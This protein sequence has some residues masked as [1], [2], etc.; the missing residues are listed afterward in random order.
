MKTKP[1]KE[2]KKELKLD[3]YLE[4][5]EL[6]TGGFSAKI[7]YFDIIGLGGTLEEAEEDFHNKWES[8]K[9]LM[10]LGHKSNLEAKGNNTRIQTFEVDI[11]VRLL[12]KITVLNDTY[13]RCK[14]NPELLEYFR[15]FGERDKIQKLVLPLT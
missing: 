14:S 11:P 4:F 5:N 9:E 15:Q 2:L 7:I 1:Y 8:Y 3:L 10:K 13:Q 6:E 12:K